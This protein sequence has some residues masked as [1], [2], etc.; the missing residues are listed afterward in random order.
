MCMYVY[1][2]IY[3]CMYV[4]QYVCEWYGMDLNI[5]L[6]LVFIWLYYVN[7]MLEQQIDTLYVCMYVCMHVTSGGNICAH[8]KQLFA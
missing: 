2:F 8:E 4:V 6:Y 3:V 5:C 7:M 1:V